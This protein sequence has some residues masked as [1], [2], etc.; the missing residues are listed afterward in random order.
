MKGTALEQDEIQLHEN[1]KRLPLSHI[2]QATSFVRLRE[3]YNLTE[4]Q[5]AHIV[6]KSISHISQHITILKSGSAILDALSKNSITFSV[7]R[8]LSHI[9]NDQYRNRYLEYAITSGASLKTIESWVKELKQ[10]P[11]DEQPTPALTALPSSPGNNEPPTCD[12]E[13]CESTVK[14]S[15]I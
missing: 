9:K 1:L 10:E 13:L 7:A 3:K 11:L 14:T 5:V 4:K 8:E 2:D 12:C 15:T 6:G